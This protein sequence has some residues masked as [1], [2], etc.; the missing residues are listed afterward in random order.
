MTATWR[1]REELIVQLVTLHRQGLSRR[2]LARA[3][4][5]SRNTVRLLL[6]THAT[7]RVTEHKAL[8]PRPA[9]APRA[10]QVDAFQARITGLLQQ[11]PDITAQRV[12]ETLREEGFPGGYTAVKKSLRRLR[13]PPR[14]EPS[15]A[16]PDYGPGEMAE[17]DWSPYDITFTDGH[18]ETV[19]A[20]SYVLVHSHRKFFDLYRH[21]DFHALLDGH[22]GAFT[23]FSGCAQTC[24]YD[25][26]KNVVLRWEG[27]QPI[28][29][30]RFLAFAAH[31]MF[32]PRAVRGQP[33]AKPRVERSFWEAARRLHALVQGAEVAALAAERV[34]LEASDFGDLK[35]LPVAQLLVFLCGAGNDENDLLLAL[36]TGLEDDLERA[37]VDAM[38]GSDMQVDWP[39]LLRSI[40]ARARARDARA[41]TPRSRGE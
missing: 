22:V 19:Q 17:N 37:H 36:L 9:R 26:Q 34:R 31:Y 10:S 25:S 29:N 3:L 39:T 32:R 20:F 13:P 23:R 1:T 24:T 30:P 7:A 35:A 38:Y 5:V 12:F 40:R 8:P 28:Y 16:T 6:A 21:A 2:A 15:L 27:Q 41:A 11:Y 4:G 33:N 18:K 14:P